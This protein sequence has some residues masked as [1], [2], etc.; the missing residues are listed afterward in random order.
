MKDFPCIV[1]VIIEVVVNDTVPLLEGSL[2]LK[3]TLQFRNQKLCNVPI[4]YET[5]Q[6]SCQVSKNV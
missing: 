2:T 5:H 6:K 4:S 1:L 3:W